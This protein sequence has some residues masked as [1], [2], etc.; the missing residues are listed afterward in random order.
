[1]NNINLYSNFI[2]TRK[3]DLDLEE[4]RSTSHFMYQF[5]K[6]HFE[7]NNSDFDAQHTLDKNLFN[8]YN[9]LLYP[10]PGLHKLYESIK[11]TFHMCN[12][13][14]YGEEPYNDYYIQC[15]LNFYKKGQ[16]IN[17]HTHGTK[18]FE[19]WHGFYCLD[20]EPN[21]STTYRI[22]GDLELDVKS[23][24][25]LIVLSKSGEDLHKSSEWHDETRPRITIAFD[26]VPAVRLMESG[27]YSNLNHWMPI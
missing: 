15:W 5:I 12:R 2:Y 17:W 26:I 7:E 1:M 24:N 27:N 16:F 19:S 22:P 4:L 13:H 8:K 23:E 9:L 6:D 10:L 25:N 14:K 11:E 20:V 18:H 21:S 3:M